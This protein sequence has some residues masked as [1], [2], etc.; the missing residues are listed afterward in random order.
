MRFVNT[1]VNITQTRAQSFSFYWWNLIAEQIQGLDLDLGLNLSLLF[2]S[3]ETFAS[4]L[5]I[6]SLFV[7]LWK[8]LDM[9]FTQEGYET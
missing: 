8:R 2:T 9:I 6:L 5:T 3:C 4:D 7:N 1:V